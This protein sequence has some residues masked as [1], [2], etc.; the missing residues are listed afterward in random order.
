MGLVTDMQVRSS[1]GEKTFNL[2]RSE[3]HV[4]RETELEAPVSRES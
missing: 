3:E 1:M 2:P 4:E